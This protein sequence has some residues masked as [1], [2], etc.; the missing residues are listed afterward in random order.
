MQNGSTKPKKLA[1]L[2]ALILLFTAA[3]MLS[4]NRRYQGAVSDAISLWAAAVI[5][6]LFPY[7]VITAFVSS[8]KI[9]GEIANVFSPITKKLFN[10]SGNVGYA[11]FI[12]LMS[13]YPVGAKTVSDLKQKG[14]ISDAESVRAAALCSSSSPMFL[15]GSIGNITFNSPLFGLLLFIT[16]ILSVVIVGLIFS[17]YRR[18]DRPETTARNF[19]DS[20]SNVLY[21]S[22]YSAVVSV[23]IVGGII[24][25]FYLLTEMLDGIGV[26]GAISGLFNVVIKETGVSKGVATGIFECTKGLKI[27]AASGISRFTLPIAAA[28]CGFGGLSV[29]MQSVAYLKKAKIKT[30][31][32]F[33][34]K[35]LSA[36]VNFIIGLIL[37]AVF[38]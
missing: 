24:T 33:L 15:M 18:K 23:L 35:I 28:I 5:P 27:I 8:L 22:V 20:K 1:E 6:A 19:T 34:S 17:F 14:L 3:V 38:L 16:H 7:L 29:I 25:V 36:V 11:L 12:S 4:L 32:F 10:V 21:D 9:T 13:G 31:P 37:S 30:A 2:A 26:L